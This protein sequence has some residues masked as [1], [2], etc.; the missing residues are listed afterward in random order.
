MSIK[1]VLQKKFENLFVSIVV[2]DAECVLRCKV[3]KNKTV[4]K[5]FTKT[6]SLTLP[7][8]ALDQALENYLM[9]LQDEYRFVYIA[10]LLDALGQG[11]IEGV[12]KKSLQRQD[13]DTE[14]TYC[15]PVRNQWTAYAASMEIKSVK[16]LFSE[17]GVDFIISPFIVLSDFVS[18]QKPKNKPTCYLLNGHNFFIM[19]VFNETRLHFGAFFKT[20]SDASFTR[21]NDLNDWENEQKEEEIVTV[22]ELPELAHEEPEQEAL[23][24]LGELS[25]LDTIDEL[26]STD[27]F[28]DVDDKTLGFFKDLNEMKEEDVSLE[29]YGRDLTVYKYLKSSL[30]EYYHNPLYPSEFIEEIIIFD[31]YEV[32]SDLIHQIEDELMMD[33]ELHKVDIGEKVCDLAIR[34][35]FP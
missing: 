11:A 35:V 3:L 24:E 22:G 16:N 5:T 34:E 32:S 9:N 4:Q 30:E 15:L 14:T 20:Q 27:T 26:R 8:E 2:N 6:F 21:S 13:I 12:D 31:G 18:A 33:V 28:S 29:L 23:D 19:A 1:T 25:D 10:Y 17:V 7:L